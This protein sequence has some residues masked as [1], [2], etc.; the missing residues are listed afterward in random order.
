MAEKN[1]PTKVKSSSSVVPSTGTK[2]APVVK[3]EKVMVNGAVSKPETRVS[4]TPKGKDAP[5]EKKP[6]AKRNSAA[7]KA[8]PVEVHGIALVPPVGASEPTEVEVASMA[9]VADPAVTD[10]SVGLT[11]QAETAVEN[12]AKSEP[13]ESEAFFHKVEAA[14]RWR[15][16][17]LY[18]QRGGRNGSADH[19]WAT[20][21]R[22]I[23]ARYMQRTA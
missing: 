22:E 17:E 6:A 10:P 8:K 14:I 18:L 16:Y 23:R 5:A 20:A 12:L 9:P 3:P 21:E 15:A 4:A 19:D 11:E 7:F 2:A 13:A 1:T